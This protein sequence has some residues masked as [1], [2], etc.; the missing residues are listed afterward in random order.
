MSHTGHKTVKCICGKVLKNCRCRGPKPVEI[1]KPCV[2]NANMVNLTINCIQGVEERQEVIRVPR[3]TGIFLATF[4]RHH[5][6]IVSCWTEEAK[7]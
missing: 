5:P 6:D 3:D 2:H 7:D 1:K 4:L